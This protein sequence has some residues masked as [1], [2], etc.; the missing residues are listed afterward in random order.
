M[1]LYELLSMKLYEHSRAKFEQEWASLSQT[2][3]GYGLAKLRNA[4]HEQ[5]TARLQA[6]K[7]GLQSCSVP[8]N[9]QTH[10][11]AYTLPSHRR[12]RP[13][14]IGCGEDVVL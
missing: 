5:P 13:R 9:Y 3:Q 11:P 10:I 7:E 12:R 14:Y 2:E 6:E 4:S 1:K 8:L